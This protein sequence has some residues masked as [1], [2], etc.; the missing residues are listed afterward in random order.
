MAWW[1]IGGTVAGY[2]ISRFLIARQV[3]GFT[4]WL[5]AITESVQTEARQHDWERH[6]ADALGVCGDDWANEPTPVYDELAVARF[7]EAL[8]EP[9][10]LEAW[11]NGGTR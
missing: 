3:R 1:L 7:A 8:A 9:G 10:A 4:A 5:D 6:V 2:A 11:I